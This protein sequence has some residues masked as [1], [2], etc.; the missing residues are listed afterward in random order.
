MISKLME[1]IKPYKLEQPESITIE[2][3][4]KSIYHIASNF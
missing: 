1:K 4:S 2:E 3:L